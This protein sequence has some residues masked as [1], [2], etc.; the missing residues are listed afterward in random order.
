VTKKADVSENPN[1]IPI[2]KRLQETSME[3]VVE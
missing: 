2:K 1:L 3:E